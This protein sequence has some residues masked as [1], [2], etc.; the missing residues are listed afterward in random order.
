ML[1]GSW[2]FF[3]SVVAT[4]TKENTRIK[5][6]KADEL[7]EILNVEPHSECCA[8]CGLDHPTTDYAKLKKDISKCVCMKS[9][10]KITYIH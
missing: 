3:I 2:I 6:D 1:S 10:G 8:R 5:S 4:E 7:G 9:K